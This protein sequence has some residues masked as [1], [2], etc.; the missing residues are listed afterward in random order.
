VNA[1][2]NSGKLAAAEGQPLIDA[3]QTVIDYLNANG[4]TAPIEPEPVDVP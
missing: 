4:L 2:L 3:A 1:F